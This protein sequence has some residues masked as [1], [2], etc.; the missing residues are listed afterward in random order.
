MR[1]GEVWWVEFDPSIG[2]EIRKTRPA[3]ILSNDAANRHLQ[4][5]IVMPLTSNTARLYPGEALVQVDEQT[6]KAM[7]DQLMAADKA[8]LKS[9]LGCLSKADMAAVEDAIRLHLGLPQ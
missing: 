1:R 7:A 9:R 3:V 6:R 5:V 2:S 4:R 8:R